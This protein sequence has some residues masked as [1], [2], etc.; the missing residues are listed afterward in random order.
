MRLISQSAAGFVLISHPIHSD[1]I[2]GH[3]AQEM[4]RGQLL[5][6]IRYM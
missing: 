5:F 2:T 6:C 4:V 1:M 3:I